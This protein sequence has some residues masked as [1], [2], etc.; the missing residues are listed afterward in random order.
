LSVES[1]DLNNQIKISPNPANNYIQ[2]SNIINT[3]DYKIVNSIG[4]SVLQGNV[5]PN[6]RIDV[7]ELAKGMYVIVLN[8]SV[9]TKFIKK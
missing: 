1:F 6:E 2:L 9:T 5:S 8:N 7:S 3:Y 4:Q